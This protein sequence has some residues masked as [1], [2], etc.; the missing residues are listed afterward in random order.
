[1]IKRVS[2]VEGGGP[3]AVHITKPVKITHVDVSTEPRFTEDKWA[4]H[5]G[6]LPALVDRIRA[7]GKDGK[8][9]DVLTKVQHVLS[10]VDNPTTCT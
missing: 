1:M 7:Q 6:L 3:D 8:V 10:S 9:L 2:V 4:D 5:P